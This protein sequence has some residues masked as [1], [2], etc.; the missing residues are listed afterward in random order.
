[1]FSK[2]NPMVG[3]SYAMIISSFSLLPIAYKDMQ[4]VQWSNLSSDFW[5]TQLYLGI[6]S[7]VIGNIC[8]SFGIKKVC[9][10]KGSLFLFFVPVV[11]FLMAHLLIDERLTSIQVIGTITMLLGIWNANKVGKSS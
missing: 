9:P 11:G 5:L 3:T 7:S 8:Y 6:F 4:E 10:A 1:M 2:V